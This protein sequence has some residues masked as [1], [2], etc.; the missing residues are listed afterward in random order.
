M[1]NLDSL[2]L[3]TKQ[4]FL[5]LSTTD[6]VKDYTFVGGSALSIYLNHRKSEDIDLF[7]W[8]SKIE[9]NTIIEAL[10][11]V[12]SDNFNIESIS[13]K[14]MDVRVLDVKLTF[15]ANGWEKL[16]EGKPLVNNIQ[17]APMEILTAMKLNTLF[18][19]A[20]FRDY[21][22][23]FV[24]NK[25]EY[26]ISDMYEII[27]NFMP[28]INKKLFQMALIFTDDIEE[29]NIEYL[30]P[31]YKVKITD[32]QKHFEKKVSKFIRNT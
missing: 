32:I 1:K 29:D 5:E 21:Y 10:K 31:K 20:K 8:N 14:Q 2:P 28:Q 15:F 3:K 27:K 18:L 6:F 7:T 9:R 30:E 17:I 11:K 12:F 19:R 4:V 16:K 24:I 13:E 22:D 26:S 23:L 25:E